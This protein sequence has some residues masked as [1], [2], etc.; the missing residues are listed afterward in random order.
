MI[1]F[2]VQKTWTFSIRFNPPPTSR[3]HHPP[4]VRK[5]DRGLVPRWAATVPS[6][7]SVCGSMPSWVPRWID[8]ENEK[9]AQLRRL[10]CSFRWLLLHITLL[11]EIFYVAKSGKDWYFE[12]N[13]WLVMCWNLR[14]I[15][16]TVVSRQMVPKPAS[17]S[18]AW[19]VSS[20]ILCRNTMTCLF[21]YRFSI[22][23][24]FFL[25]CAFI[26]I[27][28]AIQQSWLCSV[29][30]LHRFCWLISDRLWLVSIIWLIQVVVFWCKFADFKIHHL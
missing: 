3:P 11:S 8:V 25:L 20:H 29:L 14:F 9:L 21:S 4:L 16:Q 18:K 27:L 22:C 12:N 15:L 10:V 30:V 24:L 7:S 23:T 6:T 1:R 17:E 13:E 5:A 19:D 28:L 2:P 26:I